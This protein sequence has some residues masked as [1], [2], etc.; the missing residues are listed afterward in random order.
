MSHLSYRELARSVRVLMET[1][2]ALLDSENP[3]HSAD[4]DDH[5]TGQLDQAMRM[6]E[7]LLDLHP[8]AAAIADAKGSWVL[9]NRAFGRL[10]G[11]S[12]STRSF[13]ATWKTHFSAPLSTNETALLSSVSE[14]LPGV[15]LRFG[16]RKPDGTQACFLAHGALL[17]RKPDG[18]YLV[19][20][21]FFEAGA[22]PENSSRSAFIE[23]GSLKSQFFPQDA[24]PTGGALTSLP[25]SRHRDCPD[26]VEKSRE[27]LRLLMLRASEQNRDLQQR[28]AENYL[29]T[30][31]PLI[32]HLKS[33]NL[34]AS[35]AYLVQT[36]EFNL[37]HINS[38]FRISVSPA[39]RPLSTREIEICQMI[40]AGMASRQ[41]A[42]ALGLKLQT[43]M[44]HRKHIRRKLGLRNGSI[45]LSAFLQTNLE[46]FY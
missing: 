43:V 31:L 1:Q 30:V 7:A 27:A 26:C 46:A 9:A 22:Q 21:T 45:R 2:R 15:D 35:Q 19:A 6:L 37:R 12:T 5:G 39:T 17:E 20:W 16:M 40:R 32:E 25:A 38:V 34:P 8:Q 11:F 13:Q 28:I 33:M 4:A 24:P 18:N 42:Q 36:L 14:E 29:L 41:I 23:A 44:V 10:F 3:S